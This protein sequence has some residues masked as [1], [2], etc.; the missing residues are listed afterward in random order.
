MG[1][2]QQFTVV[3]TPGF[4]DSG[5]SNHVSHVKYIIPTNGSVCR[6][7]GHVLPILHMCAIHTYSYRHCRKVILV[8]RLFWGYEA[9]AHVAHSF[10]L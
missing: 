4:G 6:R 7:G 1:K 3:D 2:D 9:D 10:L 5:P 8:K